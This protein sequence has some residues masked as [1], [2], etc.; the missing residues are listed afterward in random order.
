MKSSIKSWIITWMG[1]LAYLIGGFPA[2]AQYQP[3]YATLRMV[4]QIQVHKDWSQTRRSEFEFKVLTQ[5][6]IES[7]G[8]LTLPFNPKHESLNII[9]AYTQQPDGTKDWVAPDRIRIQDDDADTGNGIYG[10]NKVKLIIFPKLKVGSKVHYIAEWK[11][12]TPDFPRQF[13]YSLSLIH[14]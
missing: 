5:Q 12:H 9:E 3:S 1:G 13:A 6:G 14:I 2:W 8:E 11:R 10:E 7:L 4:E